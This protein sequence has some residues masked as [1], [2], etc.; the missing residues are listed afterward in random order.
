[1]SDC[2]DVKKVFVPSSPVATLPAEKPVSGIDITSKAAGK[3][4][5]FLSQEGKDT[6]QFGLR[7]KVKKDG[8]SGHSYDMELASLELAKQEGD[9]L[10]E[11]EGAWVMIEKTSYFFV[12]GSVLDY[13]EA[14]TGSG[15][16]L[17]N[18]NV[19]KTCSCGSSFAV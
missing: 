19:K 12:I 6:S 2:S 13:V 16:T 1:M 17:V 7:I 10:F 9:K 5:L 15:F 18:P 3:V 4:C 8:C 11:K 14:L